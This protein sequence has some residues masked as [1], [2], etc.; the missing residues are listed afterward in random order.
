MSPLPPTKEVRTKTGERGAL[1]PVRITRILVADDHEIVRHGLRTL[2]ESRTEWCVVGEA[3]NGYEAVEKAIE[4]KPD[5]VLLDLGMP[6][7]NGYEATRRI[8][9][10]L[11]QTE[12]LVLSVNDSEQLVRQALAAGARGYLIKS[13]AGH[14]LVAAIET[15]L[16]HKSFLS[17][18]ISQP[19]KLDGSKGPADL[20]PR[21]LETAQLL[22]EGK[23]NK[24]IA[25]KLDISVKTAETHRTNIMRKIGA[26]SL[27]EVVRYAIRNGLVEP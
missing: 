6:E 11:P 20:T 13:D 24:E 17:S 2:L 1:G 10:I 21:E 27:A 22:A 7:L 19:D 25:I 26:H 3:V 9:E 18:R 15:T 14:E 5:L 12:V 8:R 23:T 4:L 16:R